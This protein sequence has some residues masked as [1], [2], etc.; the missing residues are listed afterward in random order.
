[1]FVVFI[2]NSNKCFNLV[3]FNEF[4]N[5]FQHNHIH[6]T[7]TWTVSRV[8]FFVGKLLNLFPEI[9]SILLTNS[10][11]NLVGIR[12]TSSLIT[13][14]NL[15]SGDQQFRHFHL[16]YCV[17]QAELVQ[18]LIV[19]ECDISYLHSHQSVSVQHLACV[20]SREISSNIGMFAFVILMNHHYYY[21]YSQKTQFRCYAIRSIVTTFSVFMLK[22][23]MKLMNMTRL[24]IYGQPMKTPAHSNRSGN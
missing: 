7:I 1:M 14:K 12:P 11:G 10:T 23:Q 17:M 24:R 19:F 9:T 13:L 16:K 18:L 15:Y 8:R 20:Y 5:I 21:Y 2:T 4:F 6:T 22:Y 3:K